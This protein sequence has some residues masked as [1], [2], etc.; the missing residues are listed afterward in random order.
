MSPPTAQKIWVP[1]NREE[2]F[3]EETLPGKKKE[4][5]ERTETV[6]ETL[7]SF[8]RREHTFKMVNWKRGFR[9]GPGPKQGEFEKC[10][11]WLSILENIRKK[12]KKGKV[13]RGGKKNRGKLRNKTKKIGELEIKGLGLAEG[14][15]TMKKGIKPEKRRSL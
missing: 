5:R 14:K 9:G 1:N 15:G 13:T 8:M 6:R 7:S 10:P 2:E 12:R 11:N 3:Q 4:E